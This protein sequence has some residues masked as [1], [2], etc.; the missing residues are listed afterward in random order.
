[1][2]T[3]SHHALRTS[4]EAPLRQ[5]EGHVKRAVGAVSTTPGPRAAQARP[6]RVH[7]SASGPCAAFVASSS[8][9]LPWQPVAQRQVRQQPP[10]LHA[11]PR[12]HPPTQ[13]HARAPQD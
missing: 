2:T 7:A 4:R 3:L 8:K 13:L 12:S 10:A 9:P 1:M 11:P 6:R 5:I